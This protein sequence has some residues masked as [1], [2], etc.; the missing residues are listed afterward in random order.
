MNIE[1]AHKEDLL[2]ILEL[3]KECYLQDI[4]A[5]KIYHYTTNLVIKSLK[6]K[7]LTLT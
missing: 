3:Q 5:L 4:K 1:L 2:Q 6:E 7:Q